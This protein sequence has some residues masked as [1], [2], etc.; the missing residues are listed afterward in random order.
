MKS[1]EEE[2]A[3][4]SPKRLA[5]LCLE[6]KSQLDGLRQSSSDLIAIIGMGCRF[7]GGAHSPEEFWRLLQN[8]VDAICEVPPGRWD[9][10]RY[11]DADP[12]APGKMYTRCGGFLKE[13]D[14]FDAE[15]FGIS[16]REA[17]RLDPQHRLLLEVSWEAL[18]HVGQSAD[19]LAGSQTGV[20]VGIGIDDYA[21]LQLKT[22]PTSSIDAYTG[23]GNAFCF[24]AG[25][26]S[27]LLGLNG[28]SLA[29][30]TAC[31]TSLVTVHLACQ[32][33]RA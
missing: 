4:L 15:F 18:D 9:N 2:I 5:L 27:Y 31:S 20:F 33:L 10:D 22:L 13:I 8:G 12:A 19:R 32:S 28:P 25:R 6:L 7:P 16:P 21:K 1:F 29:T 24:A 30:D 3:R 23:T 11:Y 26:L 17:R 14:Q